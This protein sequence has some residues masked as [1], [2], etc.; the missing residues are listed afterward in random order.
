MQRRIRYLSDNIVRNELCYEVL[1]MYDILPPLTKC[2]PSLFQSDTYLSEEAFFTESFLFN[3]VIIDEGHR[4]KNVNSKL[5]KV[6]KSG[7]SQ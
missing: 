1:S 6:S 3:T 7:L 5:C 4:L 2:N